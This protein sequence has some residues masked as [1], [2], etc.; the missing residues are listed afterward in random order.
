MA[1]STAGGDGTLAD[2]ESWGVGATAA[3]TTGGGGSAL[4]VMAGG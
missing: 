3:T 4:A 1:G 2:G